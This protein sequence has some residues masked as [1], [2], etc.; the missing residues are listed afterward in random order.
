M[1]IKRSVTGSFRIL[2]FPALAFAVTGY[3][4][5]YAVFGARGAR[6]LEDTGASLGVQ[7]QQ[8]QTLQAQAGMLQHRIALLDRPQPDADLVQELARTKL[9]DGAPRQVAIRRDAVDGAPQ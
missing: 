2:V 8:L 1:R 4:S 5:A 6:A 9:L 7:Q 3:F